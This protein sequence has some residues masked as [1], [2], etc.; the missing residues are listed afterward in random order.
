MKI[1]NYN[2]NYHV[3][4]FIYDYFDYVKTSFN[5]LPNTTVNDVSLSIK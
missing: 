3:K 1:C 5:V 4:S 2:V